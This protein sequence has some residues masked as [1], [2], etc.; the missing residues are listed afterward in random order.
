[1]KQYMPVCRCLDVPCL[2][3][4]LFVIFLM[5]VWD[6]RY[7]SCC[8]FFGLLKRLQLTYVKKVKNKTKTLHIYLSTDTIVLWG[9]EIKKWFCTCMRL[10][11]E[12]TR[13]TRLQ[14]KV[15]LLLC[16]RCFW[17]T[18]VARENKCSFGIHGEK[19]VITHSV[20]IYR[21]I[22]WLFQGF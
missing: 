22:Q 14:I 7:V 4:V 16:S 11:G 8:V 6:Q 15:D 5:R 21:Q 20:H 12:W 13:E 17:D 19:N 1:M 2:D 18:C 3:L 9:R 10:V